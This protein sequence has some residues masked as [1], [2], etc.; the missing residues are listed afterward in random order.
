MS[1]ERRP[2]ADSLKRDDGPEEVRVCR[3]LQPAELIAAQPHP[4]SIPKLLKIKFIDGELLIAFNTYHPH[5][6]CH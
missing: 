4:A 1:V 2:A 5:S 6:S 3:R